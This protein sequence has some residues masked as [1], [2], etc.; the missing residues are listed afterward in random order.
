MV[1]LSVL[2]VA[3][4]ESRTED[5][6][7]H[8]HIRACS[9]L[10]LEY[11]VPALSKGT[12]ERVWRALERLADLERGPLRL[13]LC[14]YA[15]RLGEKEGE[16]YRTRRESLV[17]ACFEDIPATPDFYSI[18]MNL[19]NTSSL[20]HICTPPTKDHWI[21]GSR[22]ELFRKGQEML[23]DIFV[24]SEKHLLLWRRL[25]VRYDEEIESG[26]DEDHATTMHLL[27]ATL[28]ESKGMLE[29]A[30][31]RYKERLWA[32]RQSTPVVVPPKPRPPAWYSR[33]ARK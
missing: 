2:I 25:L 33:W 31:P 9:R 24:G 8:P 28:L 1:G 3:L 11:L 5:P 30:S 23:Q 13:G 17:L 18:R 29:Q 4:I 20:A 15:W 21:Y 6:I 27:L 7:W 12:G 22:S 32:S 10:A 14:W 26:A 16:A 19:T